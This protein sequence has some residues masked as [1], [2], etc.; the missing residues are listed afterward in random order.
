LPYRGICLPPFS[1]GCGGSGFLLRRLDDRAY[2]KDAEN[3]EHCRTQG[4]IPRKT[5]RK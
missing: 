5:I 2:L 1:A 3:G 4:L